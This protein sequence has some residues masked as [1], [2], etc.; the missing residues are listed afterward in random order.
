VFYAPPW[1]NLCTNV[2]W[3]DLADPIS[4][5][6]KIAERTHGDIGVESDSIFARESVEKGQRLGG[7]STRNDQ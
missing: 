2:A 1:L 5:A 4:S 7:I 3:S 6:V